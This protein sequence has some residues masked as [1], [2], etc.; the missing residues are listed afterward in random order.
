MQ[1]SRWLLEDGSQQLVGCSLEAWVYQ[2]ALGRERDVQGDEKT[3][4][5]DI[6]QSAKK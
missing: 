6:M 2:L 3:N 1:S 5:R 4:H